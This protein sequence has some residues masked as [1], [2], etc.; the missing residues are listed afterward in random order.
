MLT[1]YNA[2]GSRVETQVR[3]VR[4]I[5]GW[6]NVY[7]VATGE[8]VTMAPEAFEAVFGT[9]GRNVKSGCDSILPQVADRIFGREAAITA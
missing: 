5:V 2:N 8:M 1:W 7:D 3:F 4:T 6:F 9:K